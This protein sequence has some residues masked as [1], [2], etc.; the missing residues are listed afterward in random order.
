[1]TLLD[2]ALSALLNVVLFAVLPF[3]V[4]FAH[5]WWRYHRGLLETARRAG[6]QLGDI[7]Y[8][9][10]SVVVAVVATLPLVIWP[11]PLEPFLRD[12]SPLRPF[13]GLGFSGKAI[14]MALLYG[15]VKTGFSEELLFRGLIA[16]SL[17]RR[18]PLAWANL[19]QAL[20]FLAP[21]L[22]L[23]LI[24]P[25][26]WWVMPIVFAGALFAGWVRIK[27]GSILGPWLLHSCANV[28]TC[29]S[30]AARTAA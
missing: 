21:H 15:V 17:S 12:T 10:L 14:A 8:L 30:I 5:H 26:M 27:S 9:A 4:Y 20:I 22:L 7:R 28:A 3:A 2:A 13:A 11:P 18:F 1:M 24:M 25:E 16:G 6:L 23:L 19:L 29:L